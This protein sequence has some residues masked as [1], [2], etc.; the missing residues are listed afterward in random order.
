MPF[1]VVEIADLRLPPRLDRR[2]RHAAFAERFARADQV[3]NSPRQCDPFA[4]DVAN[5]GSGRIGNAEERR[6]RDPELDEPIVFERHWKPN[7]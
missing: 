4:A 2:Y 7:T 5:R 1:R 3:R 6:I